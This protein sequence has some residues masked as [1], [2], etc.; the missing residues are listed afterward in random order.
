M[1]MFKNISLNARQ[2]EK[3]T[4]Q[5]DGWI[6]RMT[7][8]AASAE[9][10]LHEL[11]KT[12][13]FFTEKIKDF[14]RND[15]KL[16]VAV[17]GQVKAGK[18]SFLNALLFKGQAVLPKAATP[19]TA[20]L[21]IIEHSDQNALEIE[22][23]TLDEWQELELKA[24]EQ[25]LT[26]E[27]K[28]AREIM[29]MVQASGVDVKQYIGNTEFRKEFASYKDLL[30]QLN[31]YA[32][33]N[34]ELT[35]LVKSVRLFTDDERIKDIQIVDTP[36]LNDPIVSRT[37]KTREYVEYC[38]VVFF[39]SQASQF[40]DA[41]DMDLLTRQLPQ[42]GVDRMVLIASK[43]DS[44]IMDEL[45]NHDSFEE[46]Q[47][48]LK[49]ELQSSAEDV[50]NKYLK[51]MEQRTRNDVLSR[52]IRQ[53]L[54]PLCVSSMTHNM[55]Q[56]AFADYT[57]EEKHIY[58][59]LSEHGAPSAELLAEVGHFH[60]VRAVFDEVVANKDQTLLEKASKFIPASASEA[61]STLDGLSDKL[62]KRQE[63]LK[64]GDM[65][66]L[67]RQIQFAS[68][69]KDQINA[70]CETIFGG[71]AKTLA[72]SR[73][74][75]LQDIR[76]AIRE[77]TN[78]SDRTGTEE[79]TKSYEVSVSKWWNP[80]SWGRTETKYT[81]YT[82]SYSY[83]NVSDAIENLRDYANQAA[84]SVERAFQ[85]VI[86]LGA[87]KRDLLRLVVENCKLD[88]ESF[89]PAQFRMLIEQTLNRFDIPKVKIDIKK[90]INALSSSFS[91][92][93]RD[94]ADK[95][96]LRQTMSQALSNIFARLE[97]VVDKE[98]GTFKAAIDRAHDTLGSE[99]LRDV[100]RE[101]EEIQRQFADRESEINH[102][103]ELIKLCQQGR[104]A[105]AEFV[106]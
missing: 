7:P 84:G 83:L 91:G 9:E 12:R 58:K 44:A 78:L 6:E 75:V 96:H 63:L 82:V 31:R 36:G 49:G 46:T 70:S 48:M 76:T 2:N 100:N 67:N 85:N 23:Y 40:L 18:S 30:G 53:C 69:N 88:D 61:V 5:L 26:D 24:R 104:E 74:E 57:E 33:E 22:F 56:K 8:L 62:N 16:R 95:S 60:A 4:A 41:T 65:E 11:K 28:V 106:R 47:E 35:P 38:D 68:R 66:N 3:Y 34:G 52:V 73:Q 80:F 89:D 15:R 17:I 50:L 71:L 25:T 102:N 99:L 90:E 97:T 42:K 105:L 19:K 98:V 79:R 103:A 45:W 59:N 101:L 20:T 77:Y 55:S 92:E 29:G 10:E 86:D 1:T 72:R 54:P 81:S 64:S 51:I 39:L 13:R 21:T 37:A 32:G 14:E 93:V 43:F 27:V 94:S 87:T